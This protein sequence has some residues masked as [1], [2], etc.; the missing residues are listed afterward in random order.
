VAETLF[1]AGIRCSGTRIG[2]MDTFAEGASPAYLFR[3]YGLSVE[4]IVDA[5]RRVRNPDA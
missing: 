5:C 3:K 2:I 1:E 4:A